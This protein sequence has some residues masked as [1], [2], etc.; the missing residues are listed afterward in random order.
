[1]SDPPAGQEGK[2][3]AEL[4]LNCKEISGVLH[5]LVRWRGHTLA[6]DERQ[7]AEECLE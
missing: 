6:E 5:Y 7:L 1:V 3:E 4:L 2:H